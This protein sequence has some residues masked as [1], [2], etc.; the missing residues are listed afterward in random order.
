MFLKTFDNVNIWSLI[1]GCS[2]QKS[3]L[4]WHSVNSVLHAGGHD[5]FLT[6]ST[7]VP[8]VRFRVRPSSGACCHFG[9][10]SHRSKRRIR[11]SRSWY[12]FFFGFTRKAP[13]L[14]RIRYIDMC[15]FVSVYL[16][17]KRVSFLV[18]VNNHLTIFIGIIENM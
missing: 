13:R 10:A 17:R 3:W 15:V 5:W 8:L 11:I 6:C 4:K 7:G 16:G 14:T 9:L 1:A 2:V 12:G 18:C